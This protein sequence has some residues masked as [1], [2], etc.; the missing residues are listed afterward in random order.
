MAAPLSAAGGA[1]AVDRRAAPVD[2]EARR[3]QQVCL[4]R[5]GDAGVKMDQPPAADAF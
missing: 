3:A 2:R 5:V 1:R 4:Q